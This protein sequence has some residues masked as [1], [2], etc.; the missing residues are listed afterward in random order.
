MESTTEITAEGSKHTNGDAQLQVDIL[1][2]IPAIAW[3]VTPDG[4][5]DFINRFFLEITGQ[6]LEAC[7]VPR[8]VWNRGGS[9]LPPFLAGLHPDHKERIGEIFWNGIRSG[10]GWV[11]EAPYFHQSDGRY[12]W[13]LDRAVPVYGTQGEVLRFVGTCADIDELKQAEEKNKALL[14]VSNALNGALAYRPL[15]SHFASSHSLTSFSGVCGALRRVIVLDWAELALYE[16]QTDSFRVLA[17]IAKQPQDTVAPERE[18]E[19]EDNSLGWVFESCLPLF[20][21][22]LQREQQY[23]DERRLAAA[24]MGSYAILPLL[25]EGGCIGVLRFASERSQHYSDQDV[26]FLLEVAEQIS[27]VVANLK[28]YE[29]IAHLKAKLEIENTYLQDEIRTA[30]NFKEI[31]GNSSELLK[32]LDRVEAAAPTDANV[33]ITGE[34]GSGK[35]LIARAIHSRSAREKSPLVKVNCG[36]IPAGLVE[37]E[38]F[39]HVKGAFTSASDRRVGRFELANGGTLFLD[40]VGELPLETQVKLLR[41]LQEQEFE[42]VGSNRTIKV[43]VRI[44]AATNRDLEKAVQSGHFRSDLYYRLNVIPLHVPALRNRQADIPQLVTFFIE[45]SAKRMAKAIPTVSQKTMNLLVNYG[46]PGNIREL[47]NI[48]ERGIVLSKSPVL[49]LGADLLPIETSHNSTDHELETEPEAVA[50]LED[51]QRQHILRV[52]D[53]TGWLM[54]GP[55]GA[56]AILKVHPNTLHS[57]IKRLGIQRPIRIDS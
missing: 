53:H 30:H 20:R 57:I 5:L 43:N 45:Q 12:H 38:L 51:I 15:S 24:G 40:E 29:E 22:D 46:W 33:L 26:E 31:L 11:F 13:H 2:N 35:E 17:T 21:I 23:T 18:L 52:L 49:K 25:S 44:I 36:A 54:S 16:P 56:G 37:S 28:A 48:I 32:L 10:Q 41:V 42:P 50:T 8:G 14:E 34:T 1:Q 9:D 4:Q 47:Q 27:L 6:T 7:T 55:K 19:R 39:G 3:T